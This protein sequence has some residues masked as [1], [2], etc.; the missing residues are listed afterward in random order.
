MTM[1][2]YDDVVLASEVDPEPLPMLWRDRIP[3]GSLSVVAGDPGAGKSTLEA[4][5]AAEL[6]LVGLRGIVSNLED[7]LPSVQ[8]P[9]LEVAGADLQL[10]SL[11]PQEAAPVL[12]RDM[13]RVAALI[14]RVGASYLILDPVGAH[15]SPERLVHDRPTLRRLSQVAR[16]TMC[17]IIMIHHTT[18]RGEVGGPNAGLIGTS[19]AVHV[20]GFDPEDEDRRALACQKI[21]GVD[22]PPTLVLEHDTVELKSTKGLVDAG[23]MIV[24]GEVIVE[25]TQVRKRGKKHVERDKACAEWLS[26]FLAAG[27]DGGQL[28]TAVKSEGGRAGYGWQTLQRIGVKLG[29]EKV[30]VGFGG[31]GFW[32]WRLPDAHPLRAKRDPDA[33]AEGAAVDG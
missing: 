15:F 26:L 20:L 14:R 13:D 22:F 25:S 18:K 7:D 17:A 2:L 33:E 24:A 6:S 12:P 10:V 16:G 9:R 21:N 8:R 30:R 11:I 23:R 31:D 4:L 28:S 5:I 1:G 27:E 19:R 32:T 3:A 29:V